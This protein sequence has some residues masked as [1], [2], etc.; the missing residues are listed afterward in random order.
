MSPKLR[1]VLEFSYIYIHTH[2][3]KAL[4]AT[5]F[6]ASLHALLAYVHYRHRLC[7][8]IFSHAVVVLRCELI[9]FV[10][11]SDQRSCS[12]T[13]RNKCHTPL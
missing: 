5:V 4:S 10:L 13:Q 7:S 3:A 8:G 1:T 2:V 11:T 6:V 12:S 9:V